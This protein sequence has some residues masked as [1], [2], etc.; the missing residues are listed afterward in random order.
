MAGGIARAVKAGETECR[1]VRLAALLHDIGHG[2]FSHVAEPILRK[3]SSHEKLPKNVNESKIHE[4]IS[5][6]IILT[7]RELARLISEQQR[8]H[9]VGLL[10]GNFAEAY[11]QEIVSGPIDADKQDYLLRDSLYCGVKYGIYDQDRLRNTLCV[12]RDEDDSVL[13]ISV[14]GIHALEQFV[15]AKYYMTTQ[16]YRHKIRLITDQ[17]IGRGISLGI[18]R[19][20]IKWL[21]AIYSYDGSEEYVQEYLNWYDDRLVSHVLDDTSTP[22]GFAK[23]IFRRLQ[24]RRLFK[25]IF[26]ADP[27]DFPNP[28]TRNFVFGNSTGFFPT[29]EREVAARFEIPEEHVIAYMISFDAATKTESEIPVLESLKTTPFH[30]TSTLFNSVD[31]KIRE[32]TLHVYAPFECRDEKEKNRRLREFKEGIIEIIERLADPQLSLGPSGGGA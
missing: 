27:N 4:L 21:E 11:L 15:L 20:R 14:D 25:I 6:Q 8:E 2:P 31:E 16:V 18:E 5:A 12:H 17:M 10:Q 7:N 22:D 29:L 28:N 9:I 30:E 19:D 23:Y 26:E 1:L 24:Q 32:Q 3:H 13:A